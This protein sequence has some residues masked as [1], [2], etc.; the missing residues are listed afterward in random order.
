MAK[1]VGRLGWRRATLLATL[2]AWTLAC[3]QEPPV[4]AEATPAAVT[5]KLDFA[6][7]PL[8]EVPL[9]ID[10]ATRYDAASPTRRRLNASVLA[11]TVFERDTRERIDRMDGWGVFAPISI[12]FSGAI[13]PMSVRTAHA[14]GFDHPENDAI[15]V[16]DL[17]PGSPQY[18]QIQDL[19]IG[20]G[21]YPTTLEDLDGYWEHDARG[22]T[23]SVALEEVDEDANGNGVLDAGEDSDL[24]GVLDQPNYLPPFQAKTNQP[25]KTD[26]VAR[27][28]AQMPFYERETNTLLIRLMKP[29]RTR[30]TYAV[31]VTRRVKDAKG[32]PVGSPFRGVHHA[33]QY[34]ALETLPAVLSQHP[35]TFGQLRAEDLA[36][37]W[38]FTT[39]SVLQDLQAVRN[40]LY[41]SGVQSHL[42]SEF[43]PDLSKLW[44]VWDK[45][46]DDDGKSRTPNLFVIPGE[47][48]L[49]IVKLISAAGIGFD[50][51][52][53]T[54][55]G[56]RAL[57]SLQ[58]VD[59]HAFGSFATPMLMP[60]KDAHG[61][62]LSYNQM[63]WP[64]DLEHKP[65]KASAEQVTF[66]LAVPRK[67]VSPRK[68]GK[69]AG[70][71]IL[72]HGYTGNKM[73][74]MQFAGY[75]AR[76]G[77][78]TLCLENVSHGFAGLSSSDM[79]L[80]EGVLGSIGLPGVPA[81]LTANRSWDQDGDGEEDSGGDFWT[82]YTFHTRDVLRQ[83]AVDYMQLVRILRAFDG[84]R[85]WAF[86]SNHDGKVD[87]KD[88]A[89]DF[90]G[91]GVVDI[92]GPDA[93]ASGKVPIGMTG[94]SL[95]GMMAAIMG[96]CEPHIK[97]VVPM[98]AGGGL[99]DVGVR[100][101]QGGVREAVMLRVMGPL[102]IGY[103]E[104]DGVTTI[105]AVMPRLNGTAR[106]PVA[107][108]P[109]LQPGD[110]VLVE[111]LSNGEYDCARVLPSGGW[112]VHIA[113][114]V[115]R[116][117]PEK[118]RLRFFAGDA[119]VPG[120]R[121]EA[122]GKACKLKADAKLLNTVDK[123]GMNV[124]FHFQSV[125]LKYL[126]GQPLAPL[127]EGMGLHR[128]RP[129]LRRF[130]GFAQLVLDAA[131][132]AVLAQHFQSGEMKFANGDVVDTHAIVMT[133][134]GDMNVPPSTGASIA[135]AAGLL[136]Y[137]TPRAEWGNR[138]TAQV[139]V[140]NAVLEGV[141]KIPYWKAEIPYIDATQ[142]SV[143][144]DVED[145]SGSA[146]LSATPEQAPFGLGHDGFAAPRLATPLWK[147]GLGKDKSGGLSGALF[148]YV[149]PTG[150]HDIDFPGEQ[151]DRSAKTCKQPAHAQ[152]PAC[153]QAAKQG[154]FD[155]GALLM[156]GIARYIVTSG[157]E[158]PLQ[159]CQSTWTCPG[160]PPVPAGR[161]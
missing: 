75:F 14:D 100:S 77:L 83:S 97:A 68:D 161:Y 108:V 48:M 52:P 69:P 60:R 120:V 106:V 148:P 78:A 114:S 87:A 15:Y 119:F 61:Q 80:I 124:D 136:D 4:L 152:D 111:N 132:P 25:A 44:P 23:L 113:S 31:L 99:S 35:K 125:P 104:K 142:R 92:G 157:K 107:Q 103:P 105:K 138:T 65:A 128:A 134:I 153:L 82:A 12:P 53:G 96:G 2:A 135:R 7:K 6:H 116:D 160:I 131:D 29:L 133:T 70:V 40:G 98:C 51:S 66:W 17:T 46:T 3:D 141:D 159:P 32:Q 57:E 1:Q 19:D 59:F 16:V 110:S 129:E 121:D 81:A 64:D 137:K 47:K 33:A 39:G 112:R 5:V 88:I 9:P 20:H 122:E 90:D 102:Y 115:V 95:G 42:A 36:F 109:T 37:A 30:T 143:H 34:A 89:G 55:Y 86:D 11:T 56:D 49:D 26:L 72:G 43:P 24:D 50:I 144:F 54:A 155:H 62:W 145:L 146:A 71:V 118:H 21:Q 147:Y 154:Y 149:I 93:G 94:S 45:T 38:T 10:L 156:E 13:D 67:E 58:Y 63:S 139:L 101:I 84:K 140:D 151:T 74:T 27:A 28:K 73:T 8:P 130:L 117:Q 41:G 123:F 126:Q 22:Q 79:E 127:A 18:G 158:F 76:H 150:K 91:D 85:T